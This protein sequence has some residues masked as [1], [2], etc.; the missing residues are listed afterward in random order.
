M[1]TLDT[2]EE[3]IA[4]ARQLEHL[5]SQELRQS[6]RVLITADF[7]AGC[8]HGPRLEGRGN[9][10]TMPDM[11]FYGDNRYGWIEVKWKTRSNYWK[12]WKRD[13]HG[14][15]KD[16]WEEYMKIQH[17][18]RL[19][20]YLLICEDSTQDLLMADL[21]TLEAAG[22]P[23]DGEWPR[24]GR[25]SRNWKRQAFTKV[26]YFSLKQEN[27]D[28]AIL[29]WDWEKLDEMLCQLELFDTIPFS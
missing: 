9:D 28:T 22:E 12:T 29:V 16:K 15:D 20:V 3:K 25:I 18:T 2:F 5:I 14:I 7:Q 26:G 19:P 27:Y 10:L 21:N 11:Q 13:E 17:S 4:K 1:S 24:S 8:F 23:R 6:Y